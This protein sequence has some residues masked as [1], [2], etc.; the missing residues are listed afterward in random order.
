M[1]YLLRSIQAHRFWI[2]ASE[3]QAIMKAITYLK[4]YT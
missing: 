1:Q 3:T 2:I 4:V